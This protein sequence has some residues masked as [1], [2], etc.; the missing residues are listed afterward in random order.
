MDKAIKIGRYL[1]TAAFIVWTVLSIVLFIHS[2]QVVATTEGNNILYDNETY[3]ETF[4]VFDYEKGI[5]LGRVDFTAY[6][7]K[8]KIYSIREMPNY[9]FV[10]MGR[11]YRVYKRISE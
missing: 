6:G 9:V 4:E 3:V 2:N 11:D 1:F 10:D 8:P 5:C 7:S